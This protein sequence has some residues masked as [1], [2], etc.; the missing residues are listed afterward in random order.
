MVDASAEADLAGA[1]E[2]ARVDIRVLHDLSELEDAR[3]LFDAVWPADQTQLQPNL[4]K[5]IV[6]AGGYASAAY[7]AGEPVAAAFG[8]MGRSRREEGWHEH[9]HS[10]MAAVLPG[11]R[12]QHI[13]SA[14]K[15]HQRLWALTHGI[16]TIVWTFDPLVRRNALVNLVKLGADVDGFE[17]DFYGSMADA[18]NADDPTDR[19]FAWWRVSSSRATAAGRGELGPVDVIAAKREGRDVLD[20][21]LPDDI[22]ALRSSDPGAAARWRLDVRQ[23]LVSAFAQG[24][25]IT[26]LSTT[27]GYVL[28]RTP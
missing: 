9:L 14:I 12:D 28:E 19:L 15:Q 20:V 3:R 27:G 23:A 18:I 16:D 7:R 5:A 1:L 17:V 24:R 8:F 21:A 22:V 6:H 25:C 4:M 26:G 10:H 13:G 2:R 11:Y